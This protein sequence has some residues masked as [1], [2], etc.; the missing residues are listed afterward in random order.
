VECLNLCLRL[1]KCVRVEVLCWLVLWLGSG[2]LNSRGRVV[3]V[4]CGLRHRTLCLGVFF[5]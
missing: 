4:A 3:S 5:P 1:G 2:F